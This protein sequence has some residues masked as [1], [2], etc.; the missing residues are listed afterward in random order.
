[1]LLAGAGLAALVV[2]GIVGQQVYRGQALQA[3]E[4]GLAQV[5]SRGIGGNTLAWS[6]QERSGDT[7]V[8]RDVTLTAPGGKLLAQAA[9][10]VVKPRATGRIDVTA[11]DLSMA[12]GTGADRLRVGQAVA[13]NVAVNQMP[14]SGAAVGDAAAGPEVWLA[15]LDGGS[16]RATDLSAL[17]TTAAGAEP[18]TVGHLNS[19][20]AAL[21][22]G[23]LTRLVAEGLTVK[24]PAATAAPAAANMQDGGL[25]RLELSGLDLRRVMALQRTGTQSDVAAVREVI[26][27]HDL[28]LSM[29][30]LRAG[31]AILDSGELTLTPAGADHLALSGGRV[32]A[33]VQRPATLDGIELTTLVTD[34]RF[35][36]EG[37]T[38]EAN[39]DL[40]GVGRLRLTGKGQGQTRG[41]TPMTL[42]RM[43]V[44]L[45]DAGVAARIAAAGNVSEQNRP[46]WARMA[47]GMAKSALQSVGVVDESGL[48]AR[49]TAF[50]GQGT[51][52][53]FA[54]VSAQPGGV[55]LPD[56]R[57][58]R[59]AAWVPAPGALRIAAP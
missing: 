52:L 3:V 9:R 31:P 26:R 29:Q 57:D 11:D 49:L 7:V 51:P 35:N 1:M 28:K 6:G 58:R 2:A 34:T 43:V 12:V 25:D 30:G 15:A 18:R 36:A 37:W 27:S 14:V 20:D 17:E 33:Q 50:L 19:L 39:A 59:A 45:E 5:R 53:E 24:A 23:R 47:G 4:T 21:S 56:G 42:Q 10:G 46:Q 38:G 41:E 16:L 32:G 55:A 54:L 22:D 48:D 13:E 8:L 40:K 44:R